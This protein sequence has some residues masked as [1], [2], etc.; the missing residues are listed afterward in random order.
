MVLGRL[1][2]NSTRKLIRWATSEELYAEKCRDVG[3]VASASNAPMGSPNGMTFT[4]YPAT[5]GKVVQFNTYDPRTDKSRQEL[6]VITSDEDLGQELGL[7]I[8]KE[9]LTR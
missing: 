6:Y 2:K 1:I 9:S 7:I 3:M 5:G 4:V 8:T